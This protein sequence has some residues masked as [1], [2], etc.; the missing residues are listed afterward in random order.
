MLKCL[1]QL[2]FLVKLCGQMT[3]EKE[4]F[5]QNYL[6]DGSLPFLCLLELG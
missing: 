2:T 4:I 6:T 1:P 5:Q 3:E